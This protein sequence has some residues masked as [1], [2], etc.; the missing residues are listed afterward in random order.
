MFLIGSI[1]SGMKKIDIISELDRFDAHLADNART[2]LSAQ[3]GDG[4]TFFINEYI[5]TRG[6]HC[7]FVKLRPI[8][9]VVAPNEDVFE[10][11]KRDILKDLCEQKLVDEHVLKG[12]CAG[13]IN[14][15]N[16]VEAFGFL[17]QTLMRIYT[18]IDIPIGDAIKNIISNYKK[19]SKSLKDYYDSFE[20]QRG[21]IYEE[22]AYTVLIKETIQRVQTR[23]DSPKK[24]VL[25]ID[26]LDR[27]DPAHLFRILNVLGAHIDDEKDQ[28]KFGFAKIVLVMDHR[29]TESI[30]H[31]FYGQQANYAGY[32]GK[33]LS[34]NVFEYSL[35]KQARKVMVDYLREWCALNEEDINYLDVGMDETGHRISL[36]S[37]IE[38]LSLRD[39][40]KII[41]AVDESIRKETREVQDGKY[42]TLAPITRLLTLFVRMQ[43]QISKYDFEEYFMQNPLRLSCLGAFLWETPG[44]KYGAHQIGRKQYAFN[45]TKDEN[46]YL[47]A[48]VHMEY[49]GQLSD[50]DVTVAVKKALETAYLYVPDVQQA[51]R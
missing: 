23:K 30:F 39:I 27:L 48:G 16:F 21:G 50:I 4:K 33:F 36:M 49:G 40:V 37:K 1:Q 24:C 29:V 2:I 51:L 42:T 35:L 7:I 31:H 38:T 47:S 26:D 9:Y 14:K 20:T 43:I 22:D 19:H 8:N 5:S 3:F 10:Y 28:N 32:M 46:G 44:L 17:T 11:I 12:V 34:H 45:M 13:I 25:I 15:D 6:E 41:D 18:L